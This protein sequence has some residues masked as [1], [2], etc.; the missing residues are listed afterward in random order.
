MKKVIRLDHI[1][2]GLII[3]CSTGIFF[4]NQSG[5]TFCMAP[6]EEGFFV[7]V[8]NDADENNVFISK[9]DDLSDYFTGPN[10]P[11]EGAA[12]GIIIKNADDID[13]ILSDQVFFDTIRVD[14]EMLKES[15][16]AWVH[17]I[18]SLKQNSESYSMFEGFDNFPLKGV[19]VWCNSD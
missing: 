15:H 5:G 13:K 1:G 6:E 4:S 19:L 3:K 10:V 12:R 18:I 8:A 9:E 16:E 7:P 11:I 2:T 17:V 14:R